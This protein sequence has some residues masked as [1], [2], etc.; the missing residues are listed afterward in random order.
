[1]EGKKMVKRRK[2]MEGEGG[3]EKS[4]DYSK[5]QTFLQNENS[6]GHF[7]IEKRQRKKTKK[8]SKTR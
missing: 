4:K 3:E 6:P 7:L 2:K 1:M 8:T 5:F